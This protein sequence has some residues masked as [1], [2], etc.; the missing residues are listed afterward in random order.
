MKE[1]GL[2]IH[3]PFCK[4][5]CYYCDF[6]SREW[7][8]DLADSFLKALFTEV[9]M[10]AN[11]Y[12]GPVLKS[13]FIG[14]GTPTCFDG[15]TLSELLMILQDNFKMKDKIEISIE[16]N[17]G[18]VNRIKLGLL[19]EAGVNRLSFGVQAFDNRVL[20]RLGRIHT[21]QQAEE[22]YYVAREVGFSNINLDL[23]FALPDQTIREWQRTLEEALKL[24]PEHLSTYN[25]KIE[26]GT[27][28]AKE[29]KAGSLKPIS[30]EL[31]LAMYQL[32]R[33]LLTKNGYEHYEIS[34][35]AKP[36][37]R[38]QHNQSYWRNE[39]YLALGP[40]AHFY[41]GEVRGSNLQ[42]ITKYIEMITAGELPIKEINH[43]DREDQIIETMI[44]GLRLKEG[45][46]TT[47]FKERFGESIYSIY[48][49]E[50][51]D[52]SSQNLIRITGDSISLT[53]RGLVLANDVLAEFIL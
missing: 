49:K 5:K 26:A 16:A 51:N 20:K 37:Y 44:M 14:G 1:Y 19:K 3:I 4:S 7:K 9:R 30:E 18:T 36:S 40:G 43:L 11:K 17:P 21:I 35:F 34:N 53:E 8:A 47:K 27:Q 48:S 42:S 32:T 39:P 33:E 2:Y 22:N 10:L 25:L 46:S 24:E 31:D 23:I 38:S 6:N 41:D 13:V 29:M 52:L 45:I 12:E 50:I 15:D 28:F